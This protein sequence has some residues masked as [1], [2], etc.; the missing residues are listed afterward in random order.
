MHTNCNTLV[1]TIACVECWSCKMARSQLKWGELLLASR[2]KNGNVKLRKRPDDSA[3]T[4]SHDSESIHL[5]AKKG[6]RT[7]HQKDLGR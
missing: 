7:S 1:R 6:C 5:N 3:V 2:S 4:K